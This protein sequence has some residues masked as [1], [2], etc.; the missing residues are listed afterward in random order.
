M[1]L[2]DSDRLQMIKLRGLTLQL[3]IA[4]L[5]HDGETS[6]QTLE[7]YKAT[8]ETIPFD[9]D[10][11]PVWEQ[12]IQLFRAVQG[13]AGV[14]AL[15]AKAVVEEE[16]FKVALKELEDLPVSLDSKFSNFKQFSD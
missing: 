8:F 10:S 5:E 2:S 11:K 9:A 4:L 7:S 13:V 15:L 12:S 1:A 3:L 14:S 6:S 16:S